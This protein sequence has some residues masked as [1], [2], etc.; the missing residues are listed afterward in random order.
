MHHGIAHAL[1][2]V[3]G[4]L[5]AVGH[6]VDHDGWSVGLQHPRARDMFL[7]RVT[8]T[9]RAIATSGDYEHFYVADR[10]AHHLIDP[11]TGRSAAGVSS[12]TVVAP[13]ALD[14]DALATAVFVMGPDEG[15]AL[16]EQVSE[17]EALLVTADGT[18][19]RSGGFAA[20]E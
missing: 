6:P 20:L 19:L 15:L 18:V 3:G 8:V 7:T 16:V 13:T 11:R 5:R 1:V 14:A 2:E 17:T 10:S 4:D 12:V 9:G